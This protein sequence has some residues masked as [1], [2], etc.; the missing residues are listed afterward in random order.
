MNAFIDVI[1][2]E[3]AMRAEGKII[4]RD[5]MSPE[6]REWLDKDI[7]DSYFLAN[8]DYEVPYYERGEWVKEFGQK[9]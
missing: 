1:R 4:R 9:P 6:E 8:G 5:F 3:E 2:L 7:E